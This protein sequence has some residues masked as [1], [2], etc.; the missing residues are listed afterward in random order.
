MEYSASPFWGNVLVAFRL[1]IIAVWFAFFVMLVKP[2]VARVVIPKLIGF[3]ES[4]AEERAGID[5]DPI[6]IKDGASDSRSSASIYSV[7]SG[8]GSYGISGTL[9]TTDTRVIALNRFL[10]DY[11]SP[12]APYAEAFVVSA[13][14][15]GIDWRLVASISGVESAFGRLIP[16]NSNNGW[17]WK[18]GGGGN[19]SMFSSW[20]DGVQVV[21]AGLGRGYSGMTPYQIEQR[22]CPPCWAN[23]RHE[24]A[25]GVTKYMNELADYRKNL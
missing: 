17:G 22:Y 13:D 18:G 4:Y 24:W 14:D 19:F 20:A 7:R 10:T 8:A 11:D 21:S 25:N 9:I 23:P 2:E 1:G 6:I 3:S 15:A 5:L 16:Y 12:M